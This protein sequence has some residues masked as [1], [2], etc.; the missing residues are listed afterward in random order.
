MTINKIKSTPVQN[1][2]RI[3]S[4]LNN[5]FINIDYLKEISD[6]NTEFIHNML[7]AFK[8]EALFF[9]SELEKQ[10]SV[11]DYFSISKTA[12]RMKPAGA[13]IGANPLTVLVTSLEQAAKNVNQNKTRSLIGQTKTMLTAILQEIEKHIIK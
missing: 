4:S 5:D 3:N 10:I 2:A 1:G 12:H 13:Y 6:N 11:G 7:N 8:Q 9:L